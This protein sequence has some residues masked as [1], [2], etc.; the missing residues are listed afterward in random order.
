MASTLTKPQLVAALALEAN[1]S[2]AQADAVL[3]A[4]IATVTDTV[5]TPGAE[6]QI[7][8]LGKFSSTTKAARTGRNPQTGE[9]IKIA[10]KVAPKFSAA[11]ALKDA[12][13]ALPVKKGKK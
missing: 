5:K 1:V 13:N 6:L 8:G 2:N 4:L 11:K 9:E 10:A 3:T 12:I 7:P